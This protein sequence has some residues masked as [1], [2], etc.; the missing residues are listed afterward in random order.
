MERNNKKKSTKKKYTLEKYHN[1]FNNTDG[2][3]KARNQIR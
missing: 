1:T 2:Y 3:Q